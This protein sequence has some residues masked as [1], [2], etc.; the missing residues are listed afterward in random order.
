M[1]LHE[2]CTLIRQY[3]NT[4][5]KFYRKALHLVT[6]TSIVGIRDVIKGEE[7]E[8]VDIWQKKGLCAKNTAF[9]AVQLTLLYSVSG[10]TRK[11]HK[12][13]FFW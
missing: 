9:S 13:L 2:S 12:Y 7:R 8:K 3:Y 5:A 6:Y 1:D 11:L 10:N 4:T